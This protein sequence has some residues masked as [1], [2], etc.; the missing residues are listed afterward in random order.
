M[1]SH[2]SPGLFRIKGS[3]EAGKAPLKGWVK[4]EAANHQ[5]VVSRGGFSKGKAFII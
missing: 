5:T 4:V 1:C 3:L 2:H